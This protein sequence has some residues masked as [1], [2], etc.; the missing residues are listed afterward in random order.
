MPVSPNVCVGME[1]SRA[2]FLVCNAEIDCNGRENQD[3]NFCWG[4]AIQFI[5]FHWGCFPWL[6]CK[7]NALYNLRAFSLIIMFLYVL[8][9]NSFKGLLTLKLYKGYVSTSSRKWTLKLLFQNLR[10]SVYLTDL[11]RKLSCS[12]WRL[13]CGGRWSLA[14]LPEELGLWNTKPFNVCFVRS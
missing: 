4:G 9:E 2:V 10:K 6:C 14:Q 13:I 8:L 1:H 7:I 12:R 5:D 11:W 3:Q